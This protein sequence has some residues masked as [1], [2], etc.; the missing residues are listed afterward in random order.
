MLCYFIL[1]YFIFILF[2]AAVS[3]SFPSL[4]SFASHSLQRRENEGEKGKA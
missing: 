4:L 2:T 1:F 3:L